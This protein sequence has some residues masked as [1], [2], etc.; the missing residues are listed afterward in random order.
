MSRPPRYYA[1]H[2]MIPPKSP[3]GGSDAVSQQEDERITAW[4]RIV[5]HPFFNAAF[6]DAPFHDGDRPLID[7]MIEL[8]DKA[9]SLPSKGENMSNFTGFKT[10]PD[11]D[12]DYVEVIKFDHDVVRNGVQL[13]AYDAYN[14][15]SNSVVLTLKDV[16]ALHKA[17]GDHLEANKRELPREGAV[18]F[19]GGEIAVYSEAS[20]QGE[21]TFLV[22]DEGKAAWYAERELEKHFGTDWVELVPK[23]A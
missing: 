5:H 9:V 1:L 22:H 7:Y 16:A 20:S 4:D 6:D 15:R 12:G 18:R 21:P 19:S 3:S 13:T 14:D 2:N 8:L 11:F 10:E 23:D 17:L